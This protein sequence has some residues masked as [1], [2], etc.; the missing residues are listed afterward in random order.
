M[1]LTWLGHSAFH[2]QSDAQSVLIDPFWT[3][4]PTFPDGYED[5]VAENDTIVLTHGHED[6]LVDTVRLAFGTLQGVL[7]KL[8]GRSAS[9]A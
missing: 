5:R 1:Q 6:H 4:N 9:T 7:P 3:G 8:R 2:L